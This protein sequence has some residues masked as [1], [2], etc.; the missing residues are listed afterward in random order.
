VA[1]PNYN[2]ARKQRELARKARQ[3]EKQRRRSS[4]PSAGGE[5]LETTPSAE[6]TAPSNPTSEGTSGRGA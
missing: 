4:R 3:Q 1:K 6:S 2:H 5:N